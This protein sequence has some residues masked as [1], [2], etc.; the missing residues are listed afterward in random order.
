M[1]AARRRAGICVVI[2]IAIMALPPHARPP[3]MWIR[4]VATRLS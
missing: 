4:L 2:A 3:A 1:N